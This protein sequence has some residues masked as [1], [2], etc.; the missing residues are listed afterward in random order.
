MKDNAEIIIF[1]TK[2]PC[3]G[4]SKTRLI[5][6]LGPEGAANLQRNMSSQILKK[7]EKFQNARP[8]TVSIHFAGGSLEQMM[9]WLGHRH[10]FQHQTDGDL[11]ERM[12]SSISNN[13]GDFSRI[14]LIGADCPDIDELVFCEALNALKANDMVIGPT[15]DG[16]YYLIGVRGTMKPEQ[17][18][19]VFQGI[20]WS[21]DIV[22]T[23]T[24]NKIIQ[25]NLSC[26]TLPQLHDIDTYDDLGHISYHS[27]T[28]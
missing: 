6:E 20:S 24:M 27:D 18:C 17:F 3:P 23:Q 4:Y 25:L 19:P 14:I 10:H 12:T 21:T 26:H 28:Q 22:F 11:G 1:Y 16:G 15:F 7:V 13:L 5:P 2:Y 9:Q 8:V